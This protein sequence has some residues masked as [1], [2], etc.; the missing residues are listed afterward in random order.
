MKVEVGA[1]ASLAQVARMRCGW[2]QQVHQSRL[3]AKIAGKERRK[4]TRRHRALMIDLADDGWSMTGSSFRQQTASLVI[5]LRQSYDLVSVSCFV[6]R[7]HLLK[8][9]H[10][11]YWRSRHSQSC[12]IYGLP[13]LR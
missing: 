13:F 8:K 6:D 5:R 7:H 9:T 4:P 2:C 10:A 12:C 1:V 11:H 3:M